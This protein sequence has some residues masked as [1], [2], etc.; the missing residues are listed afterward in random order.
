[1]E[2]IAVAKGTQ[3]AGTLG[4]NL[5]TLTSWLAFCKS[6]E[7]G[8]GIFSQLLSC[9]ADIRVEDF[10]SLGSSLSVA[11]F[12][13]LG[14]F[15]SQ[16]QSAR[17]GS[18]ECRKQLCQRRF[19]LRRFRVFPSSQARA[20]MGGVP[21]LRF[22]YSSTFMTTGLN[23]LLALLVTLPVCVSSFLS[24]YSSYRV[25]TSTKSLMTWLMT[26]EANPLNWGL[27][28]SLLVLSFSDFGFFMSVR[29]LS[30]SGSAPSIYGLSCLV[31][32][33]R[34]LSCHVHLAT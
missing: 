20:D 27:G 13:R 22:L 15:V 2:V 8:V 28:S 11:S 16:T 25:L 5:Y 9:S 10:A 7:L 26:Y 30:R 23:Q 19:F 31:A 34:E 4:T 3:I 6:F 1:V 33:H 12:T 18:S 14:S 21:V 32:R 24:S 29:S 17:P